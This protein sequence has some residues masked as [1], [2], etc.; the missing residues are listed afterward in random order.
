MLGGSLVNSLQREVDHFNARIG[1]ANQQEKFILISDLINKFIILLDYPNE[2]LKKENKNKID[3]MYSV[4]LD[5]DGNIGVYGALSEETLKS[6]NYLIDF[7][8]TLQFRR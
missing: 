4:Y 7:L 2:E 1:K 8:K 3:E 5:Y 6:Q